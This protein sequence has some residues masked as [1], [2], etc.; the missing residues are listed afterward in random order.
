MEAEELIELQ[1]DDKEIETKSSGQFKA[2]VRKYVRNAAFKSLLGIKA[3]HTKG[4]IIEYPSFNIQPYL[5][6]SS[7][8][9][10]ERSTLFNLRA[11]TLNGFKTCFSSVFSQ[12]LRCRLGCQEEDNFDHIYCCSIL[13]QYI[14]PTDINI[15]GI[16]QDIKQQQRAVQE[17]IQREK[18]RSVLIQADPASQGLSKILDTS[19]RAAAAAR[20]AGERLR[21][22]DSCNN[23]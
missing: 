8:T 15:G 3:G 18:V 14:Q 2:L 12:D 5:E 20:G 11:E 7:L 17:F 22:R 1:I 9:H 16:Y 4:S 10:V 21:E 23:P 19:T 13:N 6:N